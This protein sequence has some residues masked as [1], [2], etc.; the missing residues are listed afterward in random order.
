MAHIEIWKSKPEWQRA[1]QVERARVLAQLS[2][3]I[4]KHAENNQSGPF[5]HCRGTECTLIWEV[6]PSRAARLR[7]E[8]QKI[9]LDLYFEPEMYGGAGG[10]TAKDFFSKLEAGD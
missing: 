2:Q 8:Y 3:L 10:L 1:S 4:R 5:L 7:A 9:S 6:R